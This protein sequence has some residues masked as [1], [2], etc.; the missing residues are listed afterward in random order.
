MKH[1]L[2]MH[3]VDGCA[4]VTTKVSGLFGFASLTWGLP[5]GHRES[6]RLS[7]LHHKKGA[8]VDDNILTGLNLSD[9]MALPPVA[10]QSY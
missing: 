2:Y 1:Y 7:G 10:P 5:P 9:W 3:H 4:N 8:Y 6:T